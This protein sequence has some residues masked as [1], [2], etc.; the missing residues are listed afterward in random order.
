MS[1][2]DV[3]ACKDNGVKIGK[4]APDK[5]QNNEKLREVY[6]G[7]NKNKIQQKI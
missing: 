2:C 7:K 3:A 4:G 6:L 5:A 1:M